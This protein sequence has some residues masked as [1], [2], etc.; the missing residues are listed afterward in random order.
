MTPRHRS[1]SLTRGLLAALVGMAAILGSVGAAAAA[2]PGLSAA[3]SVQPGNAPGPSAAFASQP[4]VHIELDGTAVAG[5]GVTLEIAPGTGAAGAA[6]K[7]NPN[8]QATTDGL[9]N[10]TF[11]GCSIDLSGTYQLVADT[12][13]GQLAIS[14]PFTVGGVGIGNRLAF[15]VQP[16]GGAPGVA[17]AQQP[18]VAIQNANGVTVTSDNSTVISLALAPSPAGGTLTCAGGTSRTVVA[19]VATFAGCSV[20]VGSPSSW[21]LLATSSPPVAGAT[22]SAFV[23]TVSHHLAFLVQP[24]GGM[25]GVAWTAQPMVAVQDTSNAT[26]AV[27]NTSIVTL[28]LGVNPSGAVLTCIGG[29]S[30][31]VVQGVATFQGCSLSAASNAPFTLV[32]SANPA[33]TPATSGSFFVGAVVR[34]AVSMTVDTAAGDVR[35]GFS[36]ATKV[37]R[38][39][40]KVTVRVLTSPALAN[41]TVGIWIARKTG[42][43]WGSFSP[44][45]SIHLD[46]TGTG[47]YVYSAGSAAWLSFRAVFTGDAG[48]LSGSSAGRQDRWM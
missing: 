27:D 24:G 18:K 2:T 20:N 35:S 36:P 22:S 1:V 46:A 3:F 14:S 33:A 9:G 15:L 41:A 11:T 25:P 45:A 4:V 10:A 12:V 21:S 13:Y 29:T 16:G 34:A 38:I 31:P 48:H 5:A 19:G 6:L 8:N 44:H 23:I 40:S 42:S 37:V 39:G 7:C 32:A 47:Y 26:I 30:R 28:S 17:W 43:T